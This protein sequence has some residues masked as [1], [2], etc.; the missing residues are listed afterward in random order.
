MSATGLTAIASLIAREALGRRQQSRGVPPPARLRDAEILAA[1]T[2]GGRVD[3]RTAAGYL[4]HSARITQVLAGR[5]RC[6][7]LGCGSGVQL[8]QVAAANPEVMFVGIDRSPLLLKAAR[9][10]AARL[11]L[12][13]VSFVED[14]ITRLAS[15]ADAGADAV[16]ATMSLHCLPDRGALRACLQ[17]MVRAGTADMAVYLEDFARLKSPRSIDY[18]LSRHAPTQPDAFAALYR[19]SLESAFTLDELKTEI[20]RALPRAAI[21]ATSP[22]RFLLVAHTPCAP[23]TSAQRAWF[24]ARRAALK[25]WQIADLDALRR[26]FALGE[27]GGDPFI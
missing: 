25:P 20:G 2:G 10:D 16:M 4:Y 9:A 11:G 18:F 1:M 15:I 8:L 24:R 17:R 19:A 22:V 5:R 21:H 7:D 3:G 13:N 26:A 14:D 23:L 12:G 27:W 6:L